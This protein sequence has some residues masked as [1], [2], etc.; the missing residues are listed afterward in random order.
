MEKRLME[1]VA[2]DAMGHLSRSERIDALASQL[3]GYVRGWV[4][5]RSSYETLEVQV[6]YLAI[7]TRMVAT[8]MVDQYDHD[9]AMWHEMFG[10]P[11][12][13]PAKAAWANKRP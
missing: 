13:P 10:V 12:D 9:E 3:C 2:E 8:A 4:R 11:L 6:E 1:M 7:M 5:D